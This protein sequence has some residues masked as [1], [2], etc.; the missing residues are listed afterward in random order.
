MRGCFCVKKL[1]H[2]SQ[3]LRSNGFSSIT[4]LELKLQLPIGIVLLVRKLN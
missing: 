3:I 2:E 4:A 1:R